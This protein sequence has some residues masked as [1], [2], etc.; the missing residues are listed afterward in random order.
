MEISC[1][2]PNLL[3]FRAVNYSNRK[4]TRTEVHCLIFKYSWNFWHSLFFIFGLIPCD[5]KSCF[6]WL[7]CT[8]FLINSSC[9]NFKCCIKHSGH[10]HPS[11]PLLSPPPTPPPQPHPPPNPNFLPLSPCL[12]FMSLVLLCGPKLNK[13]PSPC[14]VTNHRRKHTSDYVTEIKYFLS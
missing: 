7:L 8:V 6:I 2:L 5:K 1:F 14:E 9:D 10:I 13:S 12:I 4:Q 11:Y 3:L